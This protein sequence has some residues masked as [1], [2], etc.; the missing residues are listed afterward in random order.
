MV[1]CT[2]IGKENHTND[3]QPP[4][5]KEELG[6]FGIFHLANWCVFGQDLW[7]CDESEENH[8]SRQ[9]TEYDFLN[10]TG[11]FEG[12]A[13]AGGWCCGADRAGDGVGC[14]NEHD[15]ADIRGRERKVAIC[16]GITNRHHF[17]FLAC[18]PCGWGERC[19]AYWV[20]QGEAC[21][22]SYRISCRGSWAGVFQWARVASCKFLQGWVK[23]G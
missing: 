11:G 7:E 16:S 14:L 2:K 21:H 3:D 8:E 4:C 6:S 17:H 13:R 5:D 19:A 22:W 20:G 10:H 9:W 15:F 23:A 1:V 18:Q 12:L